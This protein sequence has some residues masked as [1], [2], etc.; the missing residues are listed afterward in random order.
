M[1][2]L[3]GNFVK[4]FSSYRGKKRFRKVYDSVLRLEYR[5]NIDF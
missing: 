3:L 2:S 5:C 4:G 1:E